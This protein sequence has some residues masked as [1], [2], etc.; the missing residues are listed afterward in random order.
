MAGTI[1]S[2][3]VADNSRCA[4]TRAPLGRRHDP[5]AVA[6]AS[7]GG[8]ANALAG[9]TT[10]ASPYA[11]PR[12][13]Y[14]AH[15]NGD[16]ITMNINDTSTTAAPDILG[17]IP[18]LA[19]QQGIQAL[20][21]SDSTEPSSTE[22]LSLVLEQEILAHFD[23]VQAIRQAREG[24]ADIQPERM[25]TNWASLQNGLRALAFEPGASCAWN[26]LGVAKDEGHSPSLEQIERRARLADVLAS[27]AHN[28]TWAEA[29]REAANQ[30]R[31]DTESARKECIDKPTY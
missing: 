20:S 18:T 23:Y 21:V 30:F 1:C 3:C 13:Q 19:I 8:N 17:D 28:P 6:I 7:A 14:E 24:P 26:R 29:D 25:L 4:C 22:L 5:C 12:G 11:Y 16:D 27:A 9:I 31:L 10:R 2:T 15:R